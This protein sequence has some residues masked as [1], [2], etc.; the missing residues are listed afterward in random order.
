MSL[1]SLVALVIALL[2]AIPALRDLAAAIE[3]AQAR[4]TAAAEK[5][6]KDKRNAAAIKAAQKA[7]AKNDIH[8]AP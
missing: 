1:S 2:R 4:Q 8:F 5:K 6:A 7:T 3:S